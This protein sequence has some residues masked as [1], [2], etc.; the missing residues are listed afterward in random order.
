[1]VYLERKTNAPKS[2]LRRCTLM[3][4]RELGI[5]VLRVLVG[6]SQLVAIAVAGLIYVPAAILML[7][8]GL[9]TLAFMAIE[10]AIGTPERG[11]G[12]AGAAWSAKPA[13]PSLG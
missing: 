1:M 8:I 3:I 10:D 9:V 7:V 11:H 6:L 4:A 13:A 12:C 2:R 5:A